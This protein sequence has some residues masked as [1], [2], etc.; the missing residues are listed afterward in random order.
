MST[1]LLYHSFGLHGIRYRAT[2]YQK[3]RIVFEAELAKKLI[4]CSQCNSRRVT[5]EGSKNRLLHMPPINL[6]PTYLCLK[7]HPS[8]A[9]FA[10]RFAGPSS[11]SL[12]PKNITS[13]L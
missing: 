6:K 3:G 10:G 9:K 4:V 1:S 7:V 11:L 8:N 12:H 5:K 2:R 13:T